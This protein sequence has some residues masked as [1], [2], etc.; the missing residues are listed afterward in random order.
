VARNG[1]T[2]CAAARGFLK[3]AVP[4]LI[5]HNC[6]AL[7]VLGEIPSHRPGEHSI[8]S[9]GTRRFYAYI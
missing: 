1:S 8:S 2:D 5:R 3:F 7:E 6:C 9:Q 4:A